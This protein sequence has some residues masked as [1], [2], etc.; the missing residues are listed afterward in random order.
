MDA[1]SG[2]AKT[3]EQCLGYVNCLNAVRYL[4]YSD[5]RLPNAN[6]LA[7]LANTNAPNQLAWMAGLGFVV[8]QSAY[9]YWSSTPFR[10]PYPNYAYILYALGSPPWDATL[11]FQQKGV[12]S[13]A[14]PVRTADRAAPAPLPRTGWTTCSNGTGGT[15]PCAGTGQD[16]DT[17]AGVPWPSTRFDVDECGTA[18][19]TADDVITDHLTGLMWPRDAQGRTT[20]AWAGSLAD[21]GS[22]VLCGHSDWRIPNLAEALSLLRSSGYTP[23]WLASQGFLNLYGSSDLWTSTTYPSDAARA[24]L[25]SPDGGRMFV[26]EKTSSYLAFPVR[27]NAALEPAIRVEP[28]SAV[29]GT[30]ALGSGANR[31]ITVANDGTGPL[32]VGSVG[33]ADPLAEPF[34]IIDDPCSNTTVAAGASC[35]FGVAF[36]P[37]AEGDFQDTLSIASDDPLA[38]LVTVGLDGT[39][40]APDP[41]LLED[42]FDHA[43]GEDPDWTTSSGGFM[44]TAGEKLTSTDTGQNNLAL[45]PGLDLPA[46]RIQARVKL[47]SPN[48]ARANASLVF[49]AQS[50]ASYRYV[51]LKPGKIVVGSLG[52]SVVAVKSRSIDLKTWY[53]LRVDVYTDGRVEV[54]LGSTAK[55]VLSTTF[56]SGA[57]AR[58]RPGCLEGEIPLRR[59]LHLERFRAG[60]V[61]GYFVDARGPGGFSGGVPKARTT[62]WRTIRWSRAGSDWTSRV[63]ECPPRRTA[64]RRAAR[65][66]RRSCP[67]R[68]PG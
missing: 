67:R 5:W 8:P 9:G 37:S 56:G 21:A 44:V 15:I 50:A 2:G 53:A 39:G 29:F 10:D 26:P 28:G 3:W 18:A 41:L 4:G 33:G 24:F 63:R 36:Q 19:D 45:A 17:R 31:T 51:Q 65:R 14:L 12:A 49:G 7:S 35:T 52:G 58:C 27:G 25:V 11:D 6:E 57:T 46:L 1:C 61:A 47:V 55:K 13:L 66:R 68:P 60:P 42:H 38:P 40:A 64:H 30:V 32:H 43:A 48:S 16:G 59:R 54:F 23:D 22:L 20:A 62:A 34:S